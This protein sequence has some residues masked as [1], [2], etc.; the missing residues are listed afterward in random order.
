MIKVKLKPN[1][2]IILTV[3]SLNVGTVFSITT[4]SGQESA[5]VK[6]KE[7]ESGNVFISCLCLKDMKPAGLSGDRSVVRVFDDVSINLS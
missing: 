5:Y 2:N 7:P 3:S 4:S 1:P 6:L